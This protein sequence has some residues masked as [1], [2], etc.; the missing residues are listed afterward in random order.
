MRPKDA[1][2]W[3][4]G[5][6]APPSKLLSCLVLV[7]I[8][9]QGYWSDL[10]DSRADASSLEQGLDL[11]RAEVGHPNSSDQAPVHQGFHGCPGLIEGGYHLWACLL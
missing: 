3:H 7:C 9:F 11:L 10:I 2:C 6:P 1:C 4:C 5:H 8:D